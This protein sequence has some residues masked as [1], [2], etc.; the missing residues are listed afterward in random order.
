MRVSR[1]DRIKE[2]NKDVLEL[3]FGF[4]KHF[5]TFSCNHGF[6]VT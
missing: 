6:D 1:M 4:D 2:V 5:I 3:N